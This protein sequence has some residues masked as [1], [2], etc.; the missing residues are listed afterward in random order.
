CKQATLK[1]V[2]NHMLILPEPFCSPT[3]N[4]QFGRFMPMESVSEKRHE[5]LRLSAPALPAGLY[6]AALDRTP[7][8]RA[9]SPGFGPCG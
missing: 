7:A 5:S 4:E 9:A 2:L 6:L 1:Y 8:S 3:P